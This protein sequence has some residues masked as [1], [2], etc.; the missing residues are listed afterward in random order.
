MEFGY[1]PRSA[2]RDPEHFRIFEHECLIPQRRYI[3]AHSQ[4]HREDPRAPSF[5]LR[6]QNYNNHTELQ[7]QA[8]VL[9]EKIT[10]RVEGEFG[11][12]LQ[13]LHWPHGGVLDH[14]GFI[15]FHQ[16]ITTLS[17]LL[18]DDPSLWTNKQRYAINKSHPEVMHR[19]MQPQTDPSL[20]AMLS[21]VDPLFNE[22]VNALHRKVLSEFTDLFVGNLEEFI[23][24]DELR[25]FFEVFGPIRHVTRKSDEKQEY[26]IVH[27]QFRENAELAFYHME[28]YPIGSRRIRVRWAPQRLQLLCNNASSCYISPQY[29]WSKYRGAQCGSSDSTK[30]APALSRHSLSLHDRS[31]DIIHHTKPSGPERKWLIGFGWVDEGKTPGLKLEEDNLEEEMGHSH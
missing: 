18:E 21:P 15:H 16:R 13:S 25:S 8:R 4:S 2:E 3:Y 1:C 10:P 23:T 24:E 31:N 5:L 17:S 26:A 22:K 9:W 19:Q 7:K 6:G 27:F 30:P 20:L 14:A 28:G 29:S 11:M 12:I